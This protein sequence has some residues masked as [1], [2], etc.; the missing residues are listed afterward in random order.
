MTAHKVKT[1]RKEVYL[2]AGCKPW[3]RAVYD[4][5]I[6]QYPGQWTYIDQRDALT[7]KKLK[8]IDPRYIFFL[9][10]SWIVPAEI[11]HTFECVCFHMTDVPYGRGGSPLQNLILRGHRST[12]L[13]ALRMTD[14]V[15]A[16]PVYFKEELSL[17]GSA[18][19][20]YLRANQLAAAMVD[21]IISDNPTPVP[22]AG[23]P[24]K[25]I[26]RRQEDSRI[27][28]ELSLDELYDFIRMLDADGYPHAFLDYGGWRI[29][30]RK[31]EH[32]DDNMRAEVIIKK[33]GSS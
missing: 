20:I 31:A 4:E 6:S 13:T 28:E 26:R 32:G 33:V 14:E 24:T 11:I 21:R 15:D 25:F 17:K 23:E 16:G 22:Q 9:H 18:R 19:E 29:S 8:E 27:P 12:K 30:F 1:M 7:T 5:I 10:W 2:V 3:S